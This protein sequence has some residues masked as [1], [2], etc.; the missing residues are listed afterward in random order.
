MLESLF[1]QRFREISGPN[2]PPQFR[3]YLELFGTGCH[4]LVPNDVVLACKNACAS[5]GTVTS[6]LGFAIRLGNWV[7]YSDD[8][9][10]DVLVTGP[11]TVVINPDGTVTRHEVV[12]PMEVRSGVDP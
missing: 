8:R 9:T 3:R 4:T 7:V 10:E 2:L 11:D 1:D 12:L 6:V 5:P